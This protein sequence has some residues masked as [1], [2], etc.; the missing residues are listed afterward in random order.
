MKNSDPEVA[1]MIK[2]VFTC[3]FLVETLQPELVL[4]KEIKKRRPNSWIQILSKKL[5][6]CPDIDL[7]MVT[8]SLAVDE[9]QVIRKDN[10]TY[11]VLNVNLP[12]INRGLFIY[13]FVRM[14]RE[15]RRIRPDIVHGHGTEGPFSLAAVYSGYPN[16][17]SLQGIITEIIKTEPLLKYRLIRVLE[18]HTLR[19]ARAIN[20]KTQF[21]VNFVRGLLG[22]TGNT[23]LI[24]PPI[25]EIFWEHDLPPRSRQLFFVGTL[26]KRKGIEDW[27]TVLSLLK[28]DFPDITGFVIG[29]GEAGYEQQLRKFAAGL[30]IESSLFF[31][32]L[33][34][35]REISTLYAGGGAF[36][37]PTYA[38]NSPNS[39][40]EAMAA[41]LPVVAS[42][43]GEIKNLIAHG[44]NG[45]VLPAGDI[46]GFYT[47][48]KRIYSDASFFVSAGKESRRIASSR[49]LP[50]TI[51]EKHVE[52]YRQVIDQG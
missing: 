25:D 29:I 7:H 45:F 40:M 52:M 47:A 36:C 8:I 10:I 6:K 5:G 21:S 48:L 33:A 20:P 46:D 50:D 30:G 43:V 17:V 27:L 11:H 9:D 26:I 1:E 44:S 31:K 15:I 41:G 37:L 24:E 49:W 38:D 13:P 51:A 4:T 32:G 2:V 28:K 34:D 23:Y 18:Q 35:H 3:P 42:D 22:N 19:K 14:V 16:V 39:L 12:L